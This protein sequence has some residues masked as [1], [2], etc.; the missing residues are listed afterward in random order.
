MTKKL[1]I[2]TGCTYRVF[3]LIGFTTFLHI[4]SM[5]HV[6]HG[7]FVGDTHPLLSCRRHCLSSLC[8]KQCI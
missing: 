6:L 2:M 1:I 3:V 5:R 8:N 7:L 4:A